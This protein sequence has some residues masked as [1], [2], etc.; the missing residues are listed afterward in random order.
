MTSQQALPVVVGISGASGSPI[1]R[2][3]IDR[4]LDLG[5]P[6]A[7]TCSNPARQVWHEEMPEPFADVLAAWLEHPLFTYYPVGD[8]KAPLA[9]GTCATR[10]MMV[11]PCSMATVAAIAHGFIT[12]LLQRAAEVC[13]KERRRLVLVPRET[14]L[15]ATHLENM[16]TVARLGATILPPEPP[17]YLHLATMEDLVEYVVERALGAMGVLD[18]MSEALAYHPRT[19]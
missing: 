13:L 4:L 16:L 17:F 6:V 19:E 8:L 18:S 3:T 15:S 10:G 14:P 2:R 7:A 11:V 1:A 12:N 9:S 5:V